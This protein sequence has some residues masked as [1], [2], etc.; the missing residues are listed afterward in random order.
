MYKQFTITLCAGV[1]LLG[2]VSMAQAA[3]VLTPPGLNPG[4]MYQLAFVTSTSR[5]ATSFILPDYHAH[6]Q[7]AADA[8]NIG[9]GS[10]LFGT[11]VTWTAIGSTIFQRAKDNALVRGEVYNLGGL[12]VADGFGDFWDG[13]LDGPINLNE[14]GALSTPF[15][16]WTGTGQFGSPSSSGALGEPSVVTGLASATGP[17]WVS[18]IEENPLNNFP[19]YGLSEQ[20]TVTAPVPAPS[21]TLLLGTGLVG[22]LGWRARRKAADT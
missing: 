12:K 7:A 21:T 10:T 1:L 18:L 15:R 4:D 16:V 22:L 3:P 2:L 6:V 9:T 5:D 19:L 14:T 8:A 17:E 20:L 13:S 11:D